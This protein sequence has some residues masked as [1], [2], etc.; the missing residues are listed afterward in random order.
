MLACYLL[1]WLAFD[2]FEREPRYAAVAAWD[3]E[4]AGV[5][6][7][8][9]SQLIARDP[10]LRSSFRETQNAIIYTEERTDNH[11]GKFKVEHRAEF[12][13]RDTR[14]SH[15]LQIGLKIHNEYWTDADASFEEALTVSPSR[16]S[17]VSIYASYHGLHS[18]MH[19]G[20]PLYDLLERVREGDPR[21]YYNY[22]GGQ[23]E[24][25]PDKIVPWI[26]SAWIDEQRALFR[27][28][29]NRFR[30]MV[31][32]VPAGGDGGLITAEELRDAI[33][34]SLVEPTC[35]EPGQTY[36]MSLDVGLSNDWT[37]LSVVHIG[38]D[39]RA[40]V[41]LSRWWRGTPDK[42]VDLTEVEEEV[43]RLA[44]AF[45][46]KRIVL[47]RWQA[48]LLGVRLQRAHLV[49]QF[50]TC[51]QSHMDKMI[52]LVKQTFS[53]RHI[54]INPKHEA[55]IEQLESVKVIESRMGRRDVLKFAKSGTGPSAGAHDD[56]VVSMALALECVGEEIGW[57]AMP[58]ITS[59]RAAQILPDYQYEVC[60]RC[61]LI[62]QNRAPSALSG[63]A[64]CAAYTFVA[65][66]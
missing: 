63:C 2:P 50:V 11:G 65:N 12:L 34:K 49:V 32:N 46:V 44:R 6:K 16:R 39:S 55:L 41:D 62:A 56:C 48:A 7:R 25:A 35:A 1:Y 21:I 66:H 26:S 5:T 20:V 15:G 43:V 27:H 14:G 54:W 40:V 28:A 58:A 8:T 37:S 23:G 36:Y 19:P 3:A 24:R 30:R 47:D 60:N 10:L 42:P 61:P 45:R 59:C 33:D 31:L 13:S 17:P 29:P 52:T 22:I 53:R 18:Q 64:N 9:A 38:D 4:Q 57:P 51:D